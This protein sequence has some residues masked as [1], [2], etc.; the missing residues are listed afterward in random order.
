MNTS[1]RKGFNS[2]DSILTSTIYKAIPRQKIA[3]LIDSRA[4]VTSGLHFGGQR[5]ID[6]HMSSGLAFFPIAG[7]NACVFRCAGNSVS[8]SR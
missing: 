6:S 3:T 8:P 7:G 1:A 4:D 2:F 5:V